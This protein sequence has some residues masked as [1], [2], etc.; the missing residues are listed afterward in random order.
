MKKSIYLFAILATTLTL[1]SCQ[2]EDVEPTPV[3]VVLGPTGPTVRSTSI[4][5]NFTNPSGNDVVTVIFSPTENTIA[6]SSCSATSWYNIDLEVGKTYHVIV[7]TSS[8]TLVTNF[9]GDIVINED[10]TVTKSNVTIGNSITFG[11]TPNCNL[12]Y[13]AALGIW[14]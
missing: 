4:L 10:N 9:E 8:S 13:V 3:P 5:E 6:M 12:N 2:K 14:P 7:Q 1:T 11:Y